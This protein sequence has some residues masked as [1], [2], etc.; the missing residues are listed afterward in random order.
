MA[1]LRYFVEYNTH[2][3]E[4]NQWNYKQTKMFEDYDSARKEYYGVLNTYIQYGKL[5]HVGAILF[6]SNGN[7]KDNSY[8]DKPA[9]A[10]EPN[11]E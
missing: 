6:D 5:D 4:T 10:P 3:A 9:P 2:N 7:K 1:E 8:W 11:A